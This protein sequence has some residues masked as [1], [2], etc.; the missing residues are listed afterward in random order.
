MLFSFVS[1]APSKSQA[2]IVLKIEVSL[3]QL[4]VFIVVNYRMYT[5]L[6]K[7]VEMCFDFVFQNGL[8]NTGCT[9]VFLLSYFFGMA[10]HMWWMILTLTWFLAAGIK[11]L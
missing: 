6:E 11:F 10:T 7:Q 3:M 2:F 4:I 5:R 1:R 9:I 8:G